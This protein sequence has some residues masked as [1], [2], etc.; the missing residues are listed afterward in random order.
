MEQEASLGIRMAQSM[1]AIADT[2]GSVQVLIEFDA[3]FGKAITPGSWGDL[4]ASVAK[5]H[6]VIIAY[7]PIMVQGE[8]TVELIPRVGH[9]SGPFSGWSNGPGTVMEWNPGVL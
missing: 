8:D 1:G 2:E 5:L 4:P 9:K 3:A 6:A 7:N